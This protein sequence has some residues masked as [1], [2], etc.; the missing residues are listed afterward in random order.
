MRAIAFRP[1]FNRTW[2]IASV[3]CSF[4]GVKTSPML[5]VPSR[6]VSPG[7]MVQVPPGRPGEGCFALATTRHARLVG[8]TT[9]TSFTKSFWHS[10][11]G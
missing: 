9:N 6:T 1:P 3:S 11:T 5:Y 7:A 4:H 8:F 10:T 2:W